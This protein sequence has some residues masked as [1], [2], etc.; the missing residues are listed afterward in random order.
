MFMHQA[1]LVID[2]AAYNLTS[3]WD[4][5]ESLQEDSQHLRVKLSSYFYYKSCIFLEA[6]SFVL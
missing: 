3:D 2:E 1:R 5:A 4:S 6:H